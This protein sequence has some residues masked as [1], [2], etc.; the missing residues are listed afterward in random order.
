M[1]EKDKELSP[2]GKKA[3]T[4]IICLIYSMATFLPYVS[5]SEMSERPKRVDVIYY[6]TGQKQW[7]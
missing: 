3:Q 4:Q 6:G 5:L 1:P 2:K 7:L